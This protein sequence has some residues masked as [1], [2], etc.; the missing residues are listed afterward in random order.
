MPPVRNVLKLEHKEHKTIIVLHELIFLKT[1][2][3]MKDMRNILII[4]TYGQLVDA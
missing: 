3:P 4:K 1:I 2:S